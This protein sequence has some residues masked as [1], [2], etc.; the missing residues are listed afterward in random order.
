[1]TAL[2]VL[3]AALV[4]LGVV[5]DRGTCTRR[6]EIQLF[7]LAAALCVTGA[8]VLSGIRRRWIWGGL[9]GASVYAVLWV[10]W[11]VNADHCLN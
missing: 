2:L 7:A 3:S 11:A 10:E 8:I 4:A 5:F 9:A 1:M 6:E